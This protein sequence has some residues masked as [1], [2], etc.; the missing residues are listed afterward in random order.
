MSIL[1]RIFTVA[2]PCLNFYGICEGSQGLPSEETAAKDCRTEFDVLVRAYVR[3]V[4]DCRVGDDPAPPLK[5]AMADGSFDVLCR[6][7]KELVLI[8]P[9][10]IFTAAAASFAE[11]ALRRAVKFGTINDS[12][13]KR[14]MGE[15]KCVNVIYAKWPHTDGEFSDLR[16]RGEYIY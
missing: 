5:R 15:S 8:E 16:C 2:P 7:G 12:S 11:G 13:K 9:I 1:Y 6:L 3:A 4:R 10:Q 14:T